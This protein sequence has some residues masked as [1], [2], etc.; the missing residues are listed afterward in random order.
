M[1]AYINGQQVNGC[2][3]YASAVTC[4]DKDGNKSTVQAEMDELN[5]KLAEEHLLWSSTT[6][7]SGAFTINVEDLKKYNY[8]CVVYVWLNGQTEDSIFIKKGTVSRQCFL[9]NSGTSDAILLSKVIHVKETSIDFFQSKQDSL[10][11]NAYGDSP[12]VIPTKV[13]G[14]L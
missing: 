14:I 5:K 6:A 3:N 12:Y 2:T 1:P 11:I 9:V 13:Y 7:T 10:H 4:L 8:V